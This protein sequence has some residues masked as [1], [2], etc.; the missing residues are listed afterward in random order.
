[1]K[2][3]IITSAGGP[4]AENAIQNLKLTK[5]IRVLG[6][7][8][9]KPMLQL[10]SADI[11]AVVHHS[12]EATD[13]YINDINGLSAQQNI[14]ML[15]PIADREIYV[16]ALNAYRLP[17]MSIPNLKIVELCRNKASLYMFM[18][19]NGF[20]VPEGF[21]LIKKAIAIEKPMW[22]RATIGAGGYLAQRVDSKKDI[23]AFL[24]LNR[25]LKRDFMLCDYLAGR[26]FCWTSLWVDGELVCSVTKERLK[27]VYDRIGTTAIQQTVHKKEI[28][29]LCEDVIKCLIDLYDESMTA[30]MMVDLKENGGSVYITEINAG[31]TGTVSLFFSLASKLV[32]NDYRVNFHYQLFRAHHN[33]KLLPTSKHD[34]LPQHMTYIRHI[35][36]GSL[37]LWQDKRIQYP[38]KYRKEE[39]A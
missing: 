37:L 23:E 6:I 18:K 13:M 15:I 2:T 8:N 1:M 33:L 10:S 7:D 34:A 35:D 20:S 14:T 9:D 24:H 4:A 11:K 3:I 17:K 28:S 30:L 19:E 29:R 25:N 36:M 16:A 32:Y 5:N 31:R 26:N 12:S 39:L 27:W 22:M 21:Q 38:I